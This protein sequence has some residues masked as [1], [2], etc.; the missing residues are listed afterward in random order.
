MR[1]TRISVLFLFLGAL[2]LTWAQEGAK[3]SIDAQ[4]KAIQNASA[5]DRVKMMNQFKERLANMNAQE[6]SD[7]IAEMRT[8]MQTNHT[9]N[10]EHMQSRTEQMKHSE[11]MQRMDKVQQNHGGDQYMQEI[12]SGMDHTP[13]MTAYNLLMLFPTF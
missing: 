8:Q 5:Q 1:L 2:T 6:R 4:I 12:K 3:Q 13:Y 11:E 9:Q 10:Q 7:A